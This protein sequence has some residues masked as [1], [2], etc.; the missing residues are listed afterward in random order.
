[1]LF[2]RQLVAEIE[3]LNARLARLERDASAGPV[4]EEP[5]S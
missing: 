4:D 2:N 3:R 5:P 1:V